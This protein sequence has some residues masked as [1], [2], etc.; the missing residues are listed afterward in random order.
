MSQT[1]TESRDYAH[2]III[3]NNDHYNPS[4]S[5]K[6]KSDRKDAKLARY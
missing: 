1:E 4:C 2:L 6:T 5:L 3:K